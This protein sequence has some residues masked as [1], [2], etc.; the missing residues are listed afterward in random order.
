M[1][2]RNIANQG[3]ATSWLGIEYLDI[4][5]QRLLQSENQSK[6]SGLACPVG[7][8]NRYKLATINIETGLSPDSVIRVTCC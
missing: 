5:T 1:T 3:I 6:E 2:L 7:A 4:A 8:D